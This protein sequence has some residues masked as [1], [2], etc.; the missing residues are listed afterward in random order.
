M[1][2][3][4][5]RVSYR[6]PGR[7]IPQTAAGL[8]ARTVQLKPGERMARHSTGQREELLIVLDGRLRVEAESP[9]KARR[10]L[11]VTDGQAVFL[12]KRTPHAVINA[13]KARAMYLYVTGT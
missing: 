11:A 3:G 4:I 13:S 12:P 2:R 8:R 7:L 6:R 10:R 1:R 5:R 9:T